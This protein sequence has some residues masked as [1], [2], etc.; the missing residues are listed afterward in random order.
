MNQDNRTAK[1]PP[2]I[3]PTSDEAISSYHD[4]GGE[5]TLSS[6]FGEDPI[7]TSLR[8]VR[9]LEFTTTYP[10]FEV[11]FTLAVNGQEQPFRNG[12]E[13]YLSITKSLHS[14]MTLSH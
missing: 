10:D 1:V 4:M 7:S 2:H 3:I 8:A 14:C 6:T 11:F 9:E 5:L 13:L 12:L